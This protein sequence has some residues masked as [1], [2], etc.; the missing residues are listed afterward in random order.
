M[1]G[2]KYRRGTEAEAG[3]VF[4]M[5]RGRELNKIGY[6]GRKSNSVGA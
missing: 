5:N 6:G 1:I 2:L 4:T 3:D